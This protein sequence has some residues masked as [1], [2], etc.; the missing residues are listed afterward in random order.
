M[1]SVFC[2]RHGATVLLGSADVIAVRGS[3]DVERDLLAVL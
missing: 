2:A 1:F 3:G